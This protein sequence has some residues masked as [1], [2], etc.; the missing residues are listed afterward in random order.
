MLKTHYDGFPILP[1]CFICYDCHVI[2]SIIHALRQ[3]SHTAGRAIWVCAH[4]ALINSYRTIL[5]S[6]N[7]LTKKILVRAASGNG[8]SPQV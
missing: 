6:L 5:L 2:P 7:R 4:T 3:R 8:I 1:P